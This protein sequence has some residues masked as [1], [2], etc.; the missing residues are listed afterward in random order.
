MFTNLKVHHNF[1][2][3]C[4]QLLPEVRITQL[5]NL[6]LLVIGLLQSTDGHLSSLA[7]VIPLDI[8]DLSIE[9]RLRRWLK[10][11]RI[12]VQR[13]YEPF[14][15]TGLQLYRWPV[16]YVVM[17]TS[18]FGPS[19]RALVVGT[20][21]AGQ[22][23][24]LGWR[25]VKGKKGHTD[26]RLQNEL[27]EEIQAYLPPGRVVLVADSEFSAVD[28]LRPIQEQDWLFIIRVRGNVL[29]QTQDDRSF[30]LNQTGLQNGQTKFW[31]HI[32][33]TAQH[34]FGPLMLVAT[35][36]K[37]EKDPLYV[38][39]NTNNL[40]AALLVY[41]WRFWIEPLFGDYKGRGFRLA[42]T[43][44][45]DPKRLSRLLLVACIA[46]L[47]ALAT[48]SY[49]FHSPKQRLVDR[50]DRVDR[51]FFQLGYRTLKRCFKLNIL[52][53]FFFAV[54]PDWFPLNLTV[55]TVR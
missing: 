19:C 50:N 2:D 23:I 27:L 7:E 28:L 46:F 31:R 1:I 22:V 11:E 10:N 48:G 8:T 49:V 51:S 37:G 44:I 36:Q 54:N 14:V 43:R 34:N 33:W 26:P 13:W 17:D 6:S 12:D 24:P 21:Y 32:R 15:R 4:R 18:Q 45:R 38:I 5:R 42:Q 9:Q 16:I 55:L 41:S 25:V 52:P 3:H 20:A 40:N 29:V 30:K 53:D 39:T 47:W 35:W